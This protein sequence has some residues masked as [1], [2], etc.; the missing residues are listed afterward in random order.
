MEIF[1]SRRITRIG[2]TA[3]V[4]VVVTLMCSSFAYQS[5][6]FRVSEA[7]MLLCF[8]NK[9]YIISV[10]IGCLISNIFSTIG[11]VDTFVGTTATVIAGAL[12]YFFRKEDSTS[13]LVLCSFI[14]VVINALFVG[15]EITLLSHEPLSFLSV[16]L[17]VAL[18]E[19]VCV[20]VLGTLM[21]KA[22]EKNPS[23]MKSIKEKY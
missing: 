11:V 16:A 23:I 15:T 14:P 18:G 7:L 13:R 10:S 20:T 5:V 4:Y 21:I 1:S 17:S 9:D 2:I 3:A 19:F 22:F 12:I 6:Q 8:Y